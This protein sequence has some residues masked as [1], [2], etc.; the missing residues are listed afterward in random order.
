MDRREAEHSLQ[1]LESGG[2]KASHLGH[3]IVIVFYCLGEKKD[4]KESGKSQ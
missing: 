4:N 1:Y 3:F 2:F